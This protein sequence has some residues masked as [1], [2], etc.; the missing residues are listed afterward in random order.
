MLDTGQGADFDAPLAQEAPTALLED[1]GDAPLA[2]ANDAT[3]VRGRAPAADPAGALDLLETDD[4]P[5]PAARSPSRSTPA[6]SSSA[7]AASS[8]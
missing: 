5:A 6:S 4:A 7:T 2:D 3:H 1:D 8:A